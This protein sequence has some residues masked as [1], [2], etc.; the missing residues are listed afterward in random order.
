[1]N[2][3]LWLSAIAVSAYTFYHAK[4]YFSDE[5]RF[6]GILVGMVGLFCL[7]LPFFVNGAT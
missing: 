6:I 3:I 4:R 2:L 5:G 7:V 1:M